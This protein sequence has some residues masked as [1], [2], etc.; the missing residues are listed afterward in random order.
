M[1][2]FPTK[3]IMIN[4]IYLAGGCYWGVQ[5]YLDNIRGVVK[6]TVGYANGDPAFVDPSYE[7]VRYENTGHT[8]AVKVEYDTDVVPTLALLRLFYRIID[9][10]SVDRQGHDVGHNYRTGVYYLTDE[11][12]LV[13]EHTI[14]S[15]QRRYAQKI[16]V[17]V[18]P[19]QNFY[20]AEEYHQKYLDKNPGGYCHVPIR[21][22]QWVKT[23]DPKEFS[24]EIVIRPSRIEDLPALTDIYNYE[25]TH[26]FATLDMTAKTIEERRV[27]FDDHNKVNHPLY[28]AVTHGRVV[29]YVSLSQYRDKEAYA[30]TVELS[31]YV[32]PS[33]RSQGIGTLLLE[34]IL[35]VA[36]E[37]ERTHLVVSVI[38][39][40]NV[41]SKHLHSRFGFTYCGTMPDVGIKF[42]EYLS[43]DY[44]YL[45]VDQN[46]H[47]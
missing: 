26:G 34:K 27:W 44:Y 29:G 22:I 6:T 40:G 33:F 23:I 39:S 24:N 43:I 38:T 1:A 46:S 25:V 15:L 41:A 14:R 30:G 21:E 8:E 16:A 10:T 9:P 47:Q 13:A 31:V 36:R 19:L 45:K 35:E 28:S 42:G 3:I 4:T 17:E 20:T 5:K 2:C 32:D 37:D 7:Q 18:M 12:R 11:D